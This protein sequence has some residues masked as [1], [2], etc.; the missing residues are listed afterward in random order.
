MAWIRVGPGRQVVGSSWSWE[1]EEEDA[2]AVAGLLRDFLSSAPLLFSQADSIM[3]EKA[4]QERWRT[5]KE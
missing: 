4:T 3:P 5:Y 1:E 2:Q